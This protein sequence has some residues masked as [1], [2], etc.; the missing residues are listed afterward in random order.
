L[1]F[2]GQLGIT[3]DV[4]QKITFYINNN[5][6]KIEKK[7]SEEKDLDRFDFFGGDISP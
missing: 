6:G 4:S 1:I 3:G 7:E 5:F 2:P